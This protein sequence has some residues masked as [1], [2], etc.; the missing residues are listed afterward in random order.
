[1]YEFKQLNYISISRCSFLNHT[2]NCPIY[3]S[4]EAN[5]TQNCP[6]YS[7]LEA[8]ITK[9]LY[10]YIHIHAQNTQNPIISPKS[11]GTKH[12]NMTGIK[13]WNWSRSSKAAKFL[14]YC[15][16][17]NILVLVVCVFKHVFR[18]QNTKEV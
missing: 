18:L 13:C 7:S 3:S 17:H 2:Q 5:H 8:K 12:Q 1:M 14:Y 6:I 4:L 11:T 16:G 10:F 15:P 9:I